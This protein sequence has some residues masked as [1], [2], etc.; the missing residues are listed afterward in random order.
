MNQSIWDVFGDGQCSVV[1]EEYD[2]ENMV[3]ET[4]EENDEETKNKKNKTKPSVD[5][6]KKYEITRK[7]SNVIPLNEK[8]LENEFMRVFELVNDDFIYIEPKLIPMIPGDNP[9]VIHKVSDFRE[10]Y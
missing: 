2:Q 9:N 8:A 6:Q 3:E 4:D 7:P 1:L 10:D 5:G